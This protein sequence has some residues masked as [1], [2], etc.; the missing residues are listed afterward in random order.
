MAANQAPGGY[1]K[2]ELRGRIRARRAQQSAIQR[3]QAGEA[4]AGHVTDVIVER[5]SACVACYFSLPTEP[6]TA[7]LLAWLWQREIQVITPRV[8]ANELEWVQSAASSEYTSGS[9]GIR[10]VLHGQVAS[11]AQ[12]D[13]ILMPALAVSDA[14]GRLGQGGGF[15]DR[16]LS[17]LERIPLLIA[18]LNADEDGTPV[19]IE[20]HDVPV[21]AVASEIGLRWITTGASRSSM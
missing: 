6:S 21:D 2:S 12:A 15:Y 4:I 9:F 10:E 11:L 14:G 13:L 17:G 20:K 3:Q 1:S 5:Q 8:R 16:A 19:P 7:P 18:L